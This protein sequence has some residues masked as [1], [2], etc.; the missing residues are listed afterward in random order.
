MRKYG[1]DR[2]RFPKDPL[3]DSRRLERLV[4]EDSV[5]ENRTINGF[6]FPVYGIPNFDNVIADSTDYVYFVDA[7]GNGSFI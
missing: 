6:V 4:D 5:L 1:N 3:V 7:S 2:S